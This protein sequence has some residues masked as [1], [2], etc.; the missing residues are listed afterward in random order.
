VKYTRLRQF[1]YA[2]EN[3]AYFVTLNFEQSMNSDSA[4]HLYET[5]LELF[6]ESDFVCDAL[7]MLPDH[8]HLLT[9]KEGDSK[10]KLSDLICV[11]KSKSFYL[12]KKQKVVSCSFWRQGYYKHVIRNEKDWLEKAQYVTNNPVKAGLAPSAEA[13]PYLFVNGMFYGATQGRPLRGRKEP[14]VPLR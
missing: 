1:D 5:L 14:D 8:L 13:Y 2:G 10:E 9:H 11:L 7:V 12:L 4:G 3:R 6:D